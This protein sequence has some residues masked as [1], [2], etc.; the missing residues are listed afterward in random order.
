MS[1]SKIPTDFKFQGFAYNLVEHHKMSYQNIVIYAQKNEPESQPL[2]YEVFFVGTFFR[3]P[4]DE[5]FGVTAW[6]Y[7]SLEDAKNKVNKLIGAN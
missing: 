6:T 4:A 3:V 2:N 7:K 5:A 1:K